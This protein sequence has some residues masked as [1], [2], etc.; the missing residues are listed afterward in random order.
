MLPPLHQC[1]EKKSKATENENISLL[2]VSA[3]QGG[4]RG[5]RVSYTGGTDADRNLKGEKRK[6]GAKMKPKSV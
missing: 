5:E 2:H 3:P 1:S 6:C 4:G